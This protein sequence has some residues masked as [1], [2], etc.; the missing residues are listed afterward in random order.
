MTLAGLDP[1][2]TSYAFCTNGSY[3]AGVAGIATVGFGVGEEHIAHQV[4]EYITIESLCRGAV[5]FAAITA[6]L[7]GHDRSTGG[8]I[9]TRAPGGQRPNHVDIPTC[10][11]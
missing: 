1:S 11:V 5:G 7:L 2:P 8:A 9:C 4:D 10:R 3:L 6:E